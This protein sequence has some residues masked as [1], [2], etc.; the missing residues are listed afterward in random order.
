[1]RG[2]YGDTPAGGGG[3]FNWR[4]LSAIGGV[5]KRFGV[6]VLMLQRDENLHFCS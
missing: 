2:N 5:G 1:M 3:G 6:I 4:R